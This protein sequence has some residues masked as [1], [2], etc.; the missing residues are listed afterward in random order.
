MENETKVTN[1][2]LYKLAKRRVLLKNTVKWHLIIY[3]VIN[4]LLC[5]IYYLTTESGYFWPVWSITGWAVGLIIHFI[6]VRS[7]LSSTRVK[8]DLVEKEY[9]MLQKDF[10]QN[11]D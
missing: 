11:N 3:L 10:D 1:D 5:V 8:R 7:V 6:V 2:K 4:A 9:Q